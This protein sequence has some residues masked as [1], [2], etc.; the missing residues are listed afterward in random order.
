MISLIKSFF[1]MQQSGLSRFLK[2]AALV[3]L[4]MTACGSVST[5]IEWNSSPDP[6]V[7]GYNIYYGTTSQTYTSMISVGNVTNA[8]IGNLEPGTTYYFA[9]KS[10]DADGNE[11]LF[12]NEASFTD[13]NI[14]PG[15]GRLPLN[16]LPSA[17]MNDQLTFSLAPGAP[18]GA[19]IN[20]TNGVLYWNPSLADA[21]STN[22]IIVIITDLANPD[23]ST[24][25]TILITVSDY[26]DLA[27]ASMPVQTGQTTSLPLTTVSNDGITN[28]VFTL[29]WPGDRLINPTL[30]F[31]APVAGGTLQN[32]GTNLVIQL[33]TTQGDV[34]IGTNQFAQINFQAAAGQPS[35]FLELPVSSLSANKTDGTTFANVTSE[36]GA[37]VVVGTNPLLRPQ[38]SASQ[39]RALTLYANPGTDYQLQY[40]TDLTSPVSWQPLQDYQPTNIEQTVN[41]DS[42]SPVIF[43]RLMQE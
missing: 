24:Q 13:Y 27:L 19:S 36:P 11:S 1:W 30:N 41:L 5:M 20:P 39:G 26:L 9:A 42:M 14:V 16:T 33:W 32:Q 10:Y 25:E 38:F 23:A 8:T 12:S 29:N 2:Y 22:T 6:N 7:A 18:V 3:V 35:A 17:L 37:V 21:S 40:A 28:L 4:P 43:Y 34:L 15:K 31:N